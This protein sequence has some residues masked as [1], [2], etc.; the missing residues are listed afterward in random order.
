MSETTGSTLTRM[1]MTLPS[2][3]LLKL[4]AMIEARSLPS[5][6]KFIA[7]LIEDALAD[8]EETPDA[9]L[10]GTITLIYRAGL[11]WVRHRIAE[12]QRIYL[13]EVISSQHVF[14]EDEQSLEVMLVQGPVSRLTALCDELRALR[15]VQQ[16]RLVRTTALLPPL[17]ENELQPS[18][19]LADV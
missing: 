19:S 1:S 17:Y 10:A 2:A 14:L 8:S 6:S 18:E 5:R 9:V 12:T 4:D 3:L 7:E 16:V 13:K 15:G 11:G